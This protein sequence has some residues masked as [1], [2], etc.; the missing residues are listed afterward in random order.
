MKKIQELAELVQDQEG[1]ER[2]KMLI[3]QIRKQMLDLQSD[4]GIQTNAIA[5]DSNQNNVLETFTDEKLTVMTR[6]VDVLQKKRDLASNDTDDSDDEDETVGQ[7]IQRKMFNVDSRRINKERRKCLGSGS[8]AQRA[9]ILGPK[10]KLNSA[11]L[12][13]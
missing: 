12:C 6:L 7:L 9:A 10:P 13:K 5:F 11:L 8:Q 3:R 4:F 2:A 1:Q